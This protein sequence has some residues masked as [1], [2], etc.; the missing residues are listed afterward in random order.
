MKTMK[1]TGSEQKVRVGIV[2]VGNWAKYGHIPALRLLPGYEITAVSSRRIETAQ[3]IAKTFGIAA[4]FSD[5]HDLVTDQEIDMVIVLP[6]APQHAT[7]VKA[8]IAAGK[9]VY[10]E[11]PLTTSTADSEELLHLAEAAGVRHMVGLQR[12]LG[13]SA[14]YLRD[15]VASKYVGEMRSVRIHVSMPYFHQER[16][17]ALAWTL[18]AKNFSHVLA[19]YVGHFLDMLFHAVGQPKALSSI[20]A[21]QFP[22]LT[23]SATGES[24]P[25]DTPDGI[26]GIGTLENGA[27]LS[28]QVEG[29]KLHNSG[30]QIDITGTTGDLRISN[31]SSFGHAKENLIEGG[32]GTKTPFTELPIPSAYSHIPPSS[33]D[34]SVEDLAHL[35][36]AHLED[37]K[38]GTHIAPDFRDGVRMHKLIDLMFASSSTGALQTVDSDKSLHRS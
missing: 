11:W 37:R 28:F 19:I 5:Y 14:Q 7:V 22:T 16:P 24:F 9:D 35:Y 27:L 4:A 25:N 21:T 30:L 38:N 18:G 3:E 13:P 6:P 29:G 17:P 32:Q 26:V 36:A 10:S 33:L 31:P 2:G 15:L 8:A 23:L 1:N 12:R 34:V 20:I